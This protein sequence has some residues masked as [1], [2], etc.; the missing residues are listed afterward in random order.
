MDKQ[1]KILSVISGIDDDII[2]EHTATRYELM[3]KKTAVRKKRSIL[4]MNPKVFSAIAAGLV[5]IIAAVIFIAL[6]PFN[7]QSGIIVEKTDMSGNNDIYTVTYENGDR[8]VFTVS[9]LGEKERIENVTV[10]DDGEFILEFSGGGKVNIG[11]SIGKMEVGETDKNSIQSVGLSDDEE[12]RISLMS[13]KEVNLG[14][15]YSHKGANHLNKAYINNSGELILGFADG[16]TINLGRVVGRDGKD[17]V[18]IDNASLTDSGELVLVLTSG[19]EINLG[20]IKGKDGVG[21]S[22][23]KINTAGELVISYTDGKQINLGKVVGK[24][25]EDGVGIKSAALTESGELSMT[26]TNG[27]EIN[28]GNIKGKDGIGITES[29]INAAGELVISYTDGKKINLGKVVGKDGEDGV[30]IANITISDSSELVITLTDDTVMTLGN[31]RGEDG[32][33]AYELFKEKFDYSGTEEDWLYDLVNGNLA[34]KVKYKVSF[35]TGFDQTVAAQTVISGQKAEKPEIE[36]KGYELIGWYIDGEAWNF[37]GHTV[38]GEITLTASWRLLDYSIVYN[39]DGG[40][41]TN[42]RSYTVL[43][44]TITLTAPTKRGYTFTGWTY[45][46]QS[47]PKLTVTVP[48]GSAGNLEFTA[49]YEIITY[50]ITY[51]TEYGTTGGL[52]TSYTVE[53]RVTVPNMPDEDDYAFRGWSM[54]GG[55]FATDTVIPKGMTGDITLVAKWVFSSYW[56]NYIDYE[57]DTLRMQLTECPSA[58]IAPATKRMVEGA[59]STDKGMTLD[60]LVEMRNAN[61]YANTSLTVIYNYYGTDNELYGWANAMNTIYEEVQNESDYS[62]DIYCNFMS[63]ML[64]ASLKGSFA[65]L[66]SDSRST[67]GTGSIGNFFLRN[68]AAYNMGIEHSGYMYDLMSSLALSDEKLYVIAS[69]YFIDITRAMYMVPVDK[70]LYNTIA[71]DMLEDLNDDGLIDMSDFFEEVKNGD[72]TYARLREYCNEIA[73]DDG[74]GLWEV[75]DDVLGF[76]LDSSGGMMASGLMYSNT[77]EI[78][79]KTWNQDESKWEYSYPE[80]NDDLEAFVGEV[81]KIFGGETDGTATTFGVQPITDAFRAHSLLFGGIITVANLESTAYQEMMNEGGGFGVVPVPVYTNLDN[82]SNKI[83]DP[84]Q[85]QIHTSGGAGGISTITKKFTQCT[86]FLNY[87]SQNSAQIVEEYYAELLGTAGLEENE[88]MIKLLRSSLTDG[89]DKHFEDVIA[90]F[91]RGIDYSALSNRWHNVL[92]NED[93]KMQSMSD[94]YDEKVGLKQSTLESLVSEYKKLPD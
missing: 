12:L 69:D 4:G 93:Y 14:K 38:T 32:K 28:L 42:P 66:L 35:V 57:A 50:N 67:V 2:E 65:N 72:W 5:L 61:A 24:D 60:D 92:L 78:I 20:N 58:G 1:E 15:M 94:F 64:G 11:S 47:T 10:N 51:Q 18:G 31:I 76:A 88:D 53:D 90:F 21:I 36:R 41:A 44:D 91:N 59:A 63:D 73:E 37:A 43:S 56:W 46:G 45:E 83:E 79:K 26:L 34:Q 39:L 54:N 29:K 55:E 23:S 9:N 81:Y 19:T 77:L 70:T 40:S 80:T 7:N 48:K 87:Q 82:D 86:A 49:N 75:G 52:P 25:G 33:S 13:N 71:P 85:T 22:E 3:Q 6:N 8:S 30:G 68:D 27:S 16:S 17:G 74:D 62:P 89:F 84:Y